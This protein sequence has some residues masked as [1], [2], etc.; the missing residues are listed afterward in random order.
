[1]V[2]MCNEVLGEGKITKVRIALDRDTGRPRGFGHIEFISKEEALDAMEKLSSVDFFGRTLR[3]DKAYALGERPPRVNSVN[4]E[5]SI[6]VGNLDFGVTDVLL[7]EMLDELIGPGSWVNV[8]LASDRETGRSRGF[9]HID[10]KDKSLAEHAVSTLDGMDL[11]GRKIRVDF[12]GNGRRRESPAQSSED[13]LG[14]W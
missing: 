11:M 8:R 1:M 3:V 4:R 12:A 9:G 5:N 13:G 7:K 14:S 2:M 10:F 6:F